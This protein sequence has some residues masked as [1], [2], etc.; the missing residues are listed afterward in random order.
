[1]SQ[2][3]ARPKALQ[4]LQRYQG[5]AGL[6]LLFV[7]AYFLSPYFFTERNWDNI[8][9]QLA[10]PGVLAIGMTF[11]ILTAGID[12][13]VGSHLALLNVIVA[14]WLKHGANA[15]FTCLYALAWGTLIGATLG[16]LVG[17][18]KMQP[19]IVTLAAMVTLRGIA[20]VYSNRSMISGFGADLAVLQKPVL[21][22]PLSGWVLI[23]LTIITGL[24]LGRTVFG[25]RVYAI[26]GNEEAARYSGVPV[27][28]TRIAA[29]AIRVV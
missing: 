7:A 15:W 24:I 4:L 29:Y 10:I 6:A 1:M 3:S 2:V 17:R 12:L 21:A 23:V 20:F 22:L 25:R 8:L 18:L 14:T 19:F 27:Q 9:N 11:I 26:G 16:W 28:T 5:L 13:S